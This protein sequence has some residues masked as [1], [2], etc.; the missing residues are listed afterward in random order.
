MDF[1][2]KLFITP[3]NR[4]GNCYLISFEIQTCSKR[5]EKLNS[6][7]LIGSSKMFEFNK[8]EVAINEVKLLTFLNLKNHS[9]Q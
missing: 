8:R 4:K 1:I 5:F 3:I 2:H 7:V 9:I 6:V